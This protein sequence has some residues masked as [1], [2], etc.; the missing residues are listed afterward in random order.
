MT[1]ELRAFDPDNNGIGIYLSQYYWQKFAAFDGVSGTLS[2]DT[3]ATGYAFIGLD[4]G[5]VVFHAA[6]GWSVDPRTGAVSGTLDG[7]TFGQQTTVGT[8]GAFAQSTEMQISGLSLSDG[9][10]LQAIFSEASNGSFTSFQEATGDETH[11]VEGSS[12]KDSLYG[13]TQPDVIHGG[14]GDDR[15]YGFGGS[16]GSLS[17]RLIGGDGNDRI[18]GSRGSDTIYGGEGDDYIRGMRGQDVIKGGAGDD[19][20][21]G[22]VGNDK[23]WGEDGNDYLFGGRYEDVLYGGTGNDELWGGSSPDRFVFAKG[24]GEDVIGDFRPGKAGKDVIVFDDV[25][26]AS[27]ADVMD[28]ATKIV[29]GVLIT[30]DEGSLFLDR[31]QLSQLDRHDFFFIS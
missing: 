3:P 1:I 10:T 2:S 4:G 9:P 8:D 27:F 31:V 18:I 12:S 26:L 13:S 14:A 11:F 22:D 28:H 6:Q 5:G 7:V 23:L 16:F 24:A 29:G 19:Q 20:I 21:R 15:L 17:D 30:Y 25:G